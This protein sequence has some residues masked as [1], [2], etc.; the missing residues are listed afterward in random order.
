M[1][2][3]DR[4]LHPTLL[5]HGNMYNLHHHGHRNALC[6]YRVVL[7][8]SF[9]DRRLQRRYERSAEREEVSS[10]DL[11]GKI[12]CQSSRVTGEQAHAGTEAQEEPREEDTGLDEG[13]QVHT[14]YKKT[15][16]G[17]GEHDE[18]ASLRKLGGR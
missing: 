17:N 7:A 2:L 3:L 13:E 5:D 11:Q 8:G 15:G 14:Q 18:H 4:S 1:G 10:I 16:V 12:S 9:V 6:M